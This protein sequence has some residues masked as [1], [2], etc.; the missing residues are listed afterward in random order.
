MFIGVERIAI[1]DD[2][3]L[4]DETE[5]ATSIRKDLERVL[6][7]SSR[8]E[9]DAESIGMFGVYEDES[10]NSN[11]II[12]G[13]KWIDV[14]KARGGWRGRS[15]RARSKPVADPNAGRG[16]AVKATEQESSNELA[17]STSVVW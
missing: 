5:P 12:P 9:G 7:E 13:S 11:R 4:W 2:K 8:G 14:V 6:E 1:G 3:S 10:I 15:E 16:K 17:P